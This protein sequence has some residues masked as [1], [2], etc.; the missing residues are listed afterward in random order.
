MTQYTTISPI[1]FLS[2][3][4][5]RTEM[6]S[7]LK[8]KLMSTMREF[9]KALR[10]VNRSNLE[11]VFV[12]GALLGCFD[13]VAGDPFYDFLLRLIAQYDRRRPELVLNFGHGAIHASTPHVE[14]L[15]RVL[16]TQQIAV[17]FYAMETINE[18]GFRRVPIKVKLLILLARE[19]SGRELFNE[20][21]PREQA[22]YESSVQRD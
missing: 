12:E 5:N 9:A 2:E 11:Q 6:N 22:H 4:V 21:S 14:H 10:N 20:R 19:L 1:D 8:Y 15:I 7:S 13:P 18:C 3:I 17:F 16:E